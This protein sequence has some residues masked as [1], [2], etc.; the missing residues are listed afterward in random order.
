VNSVC[1]RPSVGSKPWA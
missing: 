1:R